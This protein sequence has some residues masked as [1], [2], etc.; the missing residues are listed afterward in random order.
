MA[1]AAD[2]RPRNADFVAGTVLCKPES[3]GFAASTAH[4]VPEVEISWQAQRFAKPEA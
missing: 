1:G 4:C 3:V 2:C